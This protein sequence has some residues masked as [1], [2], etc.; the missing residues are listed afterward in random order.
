MKPRS[1][2]PPIFDR[3]P[4]FETPVVAIAHWRC[5]S[6]CRGPGAERAQPRPL[7]VILRS[8]NFRVESS[9]EIGLLD[10]TRAGFFNANVPFRSAH[11]YSGGDTGA[12]FGFRADALA[13]V[14][15]PFAADHPERPF[16]SGC[17]PLDAETFLLQTLVLKKAGSS[18][19]DALEVEE[20]SLRLLGRLA[21]PFRVGGA[22]GP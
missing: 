16:R 13:D 3:R 12:D 6:S 22:P 18:S 9:A 20:L 2:S 19:R 10:C 5:R 8:G 11:P 17:G 7:I 15:G 1:S 14:F 21:E 4:V